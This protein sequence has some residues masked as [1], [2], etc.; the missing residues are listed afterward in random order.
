[1]LLARGALLRRL[2]LAARR[3]LRGRLLLPV[4]RLPRDRRVR[5]RAPARVGRPLDGRL[6]DP[7][8]NEDLRRRTVRARY[9][10]PRR[11]GS[12]ARFR[13]AA[14]EREGASHDE[15]GK[16]NLGVH[17]Q[18]PALKVCLQKQN[19]KRKRAGLRKVSGNF[20]SMQNNDL[21]RGEPGSGTR[22]L[23]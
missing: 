18:S 11:E 12:L 10:R 14:P 6:L 15:S 16:E 13:R 19:T 7:A 23:R 17:D 3:A 5:A 21:R 8:E 1:L 22:P 20:Y 9:G 4:G 2:L